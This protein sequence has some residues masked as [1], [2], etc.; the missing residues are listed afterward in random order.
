MIKW[1]VPLCYGFDIEKVQVVRESESSVWIEHRG[2]IRRYKKVTT[3]DAYVDTWDEAKA[4]IV[5]DK[6]NGVDFA[7]G[8]LEH[9]EKE[10]RRAE[11]L[12][13]PE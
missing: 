13:K 6:K 12:T 1:K 2:N 3:Y 11:A 8:R 10:L 4:L 9:T 5:K 7:K